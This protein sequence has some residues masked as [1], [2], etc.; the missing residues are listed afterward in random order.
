MEIQN[1]D[2]EVSIQNIT[3]TYKLKDTFYQGILV[4]ILWHMMG[5]HETISQAGL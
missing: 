3:T 4:Q 5:V 2:K 1:K